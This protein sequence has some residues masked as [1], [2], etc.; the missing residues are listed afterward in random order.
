MPA[1]L[2]KLRTK[3][4]RLEAESARVVA[5]LD[6]AFNTNVLEGALSLLAAARGG[7]AIRRRGR[8]RIQL[9]PA[10]Q[11]VLAWSIGQQIRAA[12]ERKGWTQEDLARASGIARPNIARLEKGGQVP[13]VATLRRVAAAL[14]LESDALLTAPQPVADREDRELAEAGLGEW[15]SQLERLDKEA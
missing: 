2:E 11:N 7:P 5:E 10:P 1:T 14:G 3:D 4:R 15:S 13:K 9:K 8:P 6:A 12:R